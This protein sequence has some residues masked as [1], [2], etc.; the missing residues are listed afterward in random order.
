VNP[1]ELAKAALRRLALQR[2]EPTPQN[3]ASAWA[4]EGGAL[5]PCWP[6]RALPVLERLV[7]RAG[8]DGAQRAAL[9]TALRNGH[10]DDAQQCLE[11]GGSGPGWAAL[12]ERAVRG[13][14]RGGRLWTRARRRDGL[15][16][17]LDGSGSDAAWLQ[18]RLQRLLAAWDQDRDD[19]AADTGMAVLDEAQARPE[20]AA[21]APPLAAPAGDGGAGAEAVAALAAALHAG[22]PAADARAAALAAALAPLA[23]RLAAD[24]PTPALAAEL[25]AVCTQAGRW[26]GHRQHFVAQLEALCRELTAGLAELAEDASWTQGQLR[27]VEARLDGGLEARAVKAAAELLARTRAQQQRLRGERDRA[28]D[29]LRALV[30]S[31]LAQLGEVDDRTGG[32]GQRLE[33]Y[34][35]QIGGAASIDELADVVQRMLADNRAVRAGV[36]ATRERLSHEHARA[37]ELEARVRALEDE[38]RRLSDEVSTDAL[39]EVANRRGLQQAFDAERARIERAAPGVQPALAVGLIDIDNFKRL[40]DSLG[41]AAGDV[42][43]KTLAARVAEALRPS[44]TVGRWGGEEFVVLLP[45]TTAPEAQQVLTRLQRGLSA[46]LFLHEGREV[47]VTFSAGVTGWRPGEGLDRALERADEALF[48]AKRSGK[49]RCCVG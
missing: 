35:R 21:T 45:A 11:R 34:D 3:F 38:L 2:L 4:E 22:L 13:L 31:V 46:S 15:Q 23:A 25:G 33:D 32:Y 20:A 18:Q 16:R 1:T 5:A 28:R 29:A 26:L 9:L 43:L 47:F 48:E 24:G 6:E 36:Q 39:T 8:D 19:E 49:N 14:E 42:A 7:L 12:I 10:W 27:A 44:D 37:A 40:N 17:V 30:H 41:H